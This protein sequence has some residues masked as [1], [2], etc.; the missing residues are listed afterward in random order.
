VATKKVSLPVT[1]SQKQRR[2]TSKTAGKAYP[3][4]TKVSIKHI[5]PGL[6]SMMTISS[7]VMDNPRLAGLL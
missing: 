1:G 3:V 2:S 7:I 5:Q 4:V 6:L